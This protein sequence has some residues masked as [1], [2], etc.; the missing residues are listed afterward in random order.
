MTLRN[1][2]TISIVQFG[3][4]PARPV[5]L[6]IGHRSVQLSRGLRARRPDGAQVSC[7]NARDRAMLFAAAHAAKLSPASP[8]V[9]ERTQ[10]WSIRRVC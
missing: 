4:C 8:S 2:S 9:L 10:R 5:A 1:S 6:G 7:T 3:L